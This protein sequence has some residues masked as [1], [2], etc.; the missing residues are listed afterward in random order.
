MSD[1]ISAGW[2]YFIATVSAVGILW[3]LWLLFSQRKNRVILR[4]D[5]TVSDT[6]H[7]WDGLRELNNPLPRWWMWMFIL[8]CVFGVFY[9]ALYPGLG[10]YPGLLKFSTQGEHDQAVITANAELKPLY[11]KYMNMSLEQVAADPQAREI[12][13][14]LFLNNC[15]QCHGSDAGGGKGFPN[16]TDHDWLY[17][18]EPETIRTSILKGR[19]GAM[20]SFKAILDSGQISDVANYVRSLSGL[21]ADQIKV[22]RG[23]SVFKNNCVGCHGSAGTGSTIVGAPNLTDR[24]WLYG[25]SEATIIETVTNGRNGKMPAH[26]QILT[27]EKVQMLAAYVWG[28]SNQAPAK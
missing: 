20:P 16:L 19:S 23:Q 12:G 26:E 15:A 6:G 24:T 2:G 1:F 13:Q 17:G 21:A 11:A 10:S 25:S 22:G 14:R 28:L 8:A 3:C 5:G 4:E 27:P 9:L 7:E 18:G